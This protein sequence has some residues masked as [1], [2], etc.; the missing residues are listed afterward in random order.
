LD[1]GEIIFTGKS[2]FMFQDFQLFPHMT[3]LENLV[4]APNIHHRKSIENHNNNAIKLLQN[5]GIVDKAECF[6]HQLSGG[7]KQRVALARSL[8]MQPEILLCDEPTSGLD[9]ATIIDVVSLLSSIRDM[10]V[11][12]IIASHDLDFITRI[13]DRVILLKNAT[14]AADVKLQDLENPIQYL[15]T[16]Y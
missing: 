11:T 16:F 5:L 9:V 10:K 1:S 12:M 2:G 7:Q 13:A 14:V 3:I 6:P 4:Y 8:M 15:K